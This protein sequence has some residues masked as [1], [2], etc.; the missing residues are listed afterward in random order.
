M[1][2]R[3]TLYS[4][5]LCSL[6]WNDLAFVVL[7]AVSGWK[8]STCG[9]SLVSELECML[10]YSFQHACPLHQTSWGDSFSPSVWFCLVILVAGEFLAIC[11]WMVWLVTCENLRLV[12]LTSLQLLLQTQKHS[13]AMH[14]G[15]ARAAEGAH[16]HARVAGHACGP[17][18]VNNFPSLCNHVMNG[19][20]TSCRAS[21]LVCTSGAAGPWIC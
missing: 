11:T 14:L 13:L 9:Q 1:L 5:S 4:N 12:A 20:C 10:F 15:Q 18:P 17:R 3:T 21:G 19:P 6:N 16:L 2:R 8:N 7:T